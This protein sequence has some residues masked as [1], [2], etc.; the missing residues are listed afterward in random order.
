MLRNLSMSA[1]LPTRLDIMDEISERLSLGGSP[2]IKSFQSVAPNV[3]PVGPPEPT[4]APLPRIRTV[5][6]GFKVFASSSIF[7]CAPFK[8]GVLPNDV[9]A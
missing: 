3:A 4:A 6:E 5:Y 8:C 1:V 2:P 9:S 7:T